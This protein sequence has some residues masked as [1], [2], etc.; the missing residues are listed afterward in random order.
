[1]S[2]Y[3]VIPLPKLRRMYKNRREVK[4]IQAELANYLEFAAI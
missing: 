4:R 1:M 2:V 3:K